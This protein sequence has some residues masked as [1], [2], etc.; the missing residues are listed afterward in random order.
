M[1]KI[2]GDHRGAKWWI[3][4]EET[5][6]LSLK[7]KKLSVG[8]THTEIPS[9]STYKMFIIKYFQYSK[10]IC[11]TYI[12]VVRHLKL[13]IFVEHCT[14]VQPIYKHIAYRR[15]RELIL[16][17]S[18]PQNFFIRKSSPCKMMKICWTNLWSISS[19][20]ACSQYRA[21]FCVGR[22]RELIV[23]CMET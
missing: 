6:G 1:L 5:R 12:K 10:S 16:F 18:R 4:A 22:I 14:H 7:I 9:V 20:N 23:F 17:C 2:L 15:I 3:F 13:S 8:Q 21:K 11:M 19:N